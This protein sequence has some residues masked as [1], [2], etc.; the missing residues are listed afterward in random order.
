METPSLR[1]ALGL[2]REGGC[3]WWDGVCG[4]RACSKETGE[5]GSRGGGREF[6]VQAPVCALLVLVVHP[7]S[8]SLHCAQ[9]GRSLRLKGDPRHTHDTVGPAHRQGSPGA[10]A[11]VVLTQGQASTGSGSDPA[12]PLG[13]RSSPAP[14]ERSMQTPLQAFSEV[15]SAPSQPIESPI[16]QPID[17]SRGHAPARTTQARPQGRW[18]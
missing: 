18:R 11:R 1:S 12:C 10:G 2:V 13:C 4:V 5:T 15:I 17:G 7:P 16:D 6:W 8:V 3:R 14:W 9:W